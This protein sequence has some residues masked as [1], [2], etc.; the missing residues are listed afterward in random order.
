MLSTIHLFNPAYHKLE[1]F[2]IIVARTNLRKDLTANVSKDHFKNTQDNIK[3]ND[4]IKLEIF[5]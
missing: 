4:K 5:K 3:G 1:P 2:G